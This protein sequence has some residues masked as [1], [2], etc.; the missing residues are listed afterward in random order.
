MSE[1]AWLIE[2]PGPNYL[3]TWEIAG[4]AEFCWTRDAHKG[5]RFWN[6]DQAD[7]AARAIR[8]LN[9]DLW[10]FARLLG[11]ARPV[12]HGFLPAGRAALEQGNG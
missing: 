8:N 12:E 7:M 4:C 2:A 5:L 11:E 3:A 9:P 10:A 6:A 1:F